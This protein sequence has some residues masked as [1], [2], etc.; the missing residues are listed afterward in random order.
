[1]TTRIDAPPSHSEEFADLP[2]SLLPLGCCVCVVLL[3]GTRHQL[4]HELTA[5]AALSSPYLVSFLGAYHEAGVIT[6]AS[7]YMDLGSLQSFIKRYG[8]IEDERLLKIVTKQA[9]L[10]LHYLH[11]QHRVHRDIKP[12]NILL[13]IRGQCRLADFGLLTELQDTHAFTDTFLGTM[14]YLSPERLK[15][16]QYSYKSDIWSMGL[17]LIFIVTGALPV[18]CSD[19]WQMLDLLS[20]SPPK[21][22]RG[23]AHSDE[24]CDFIDECLRLNEDERASA[25]Q[26]LDHPFIREVDVS[27]TEDFDIRTR[28]L[29]ENIQYHAAAAANPA[30]DPGV[31]T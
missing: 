7:E 31:M 18:Q 23:G 20:K 26:L 4:L 9:I 21:L 17:S 27:H 2:L 14:A 16:D 6:V 11:T 28:Q 3:Q 8:C 24:L 15:S 25:G 30:G 29:I 12:D 10:G 22:E 5:Y 19:Y 1:M 13:N